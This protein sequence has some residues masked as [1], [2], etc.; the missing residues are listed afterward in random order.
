LELGKIKQ[1]NSIDCAKKVLANMKTR[2]QY[3][4][5]RPSATRDRGYGRAEKKL[6]TYPVVAIQI[7]LLGQS[8][9][10]LQYVLIL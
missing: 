3:I 8:F 1:Q 10:I 5:Y 2:F 6:T 4:L 9:M 7:F